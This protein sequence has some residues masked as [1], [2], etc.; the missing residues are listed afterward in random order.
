MAAAIRVDIHLANC[1][2]DQQML[3]TLAAEIG[4]AAVRMLRLRLGPMQGEA[5]KRLDEKGLAQGP[6][7][8]KPLV[9]REVDTD[10]GDLW[11]EP[12]YCDGTRRVRIDLDFDA[13]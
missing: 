6:T 12:W 8:A 13:R 2:T 4:D 7:T 11:P 1:G 3:E 5:V 10:R 9:S